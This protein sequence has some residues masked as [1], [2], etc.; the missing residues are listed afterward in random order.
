MQDMQKRFNKVAQNMQL[1]YTTTDETIVHPNISGYEKN[2]VTCN[3]YYNG[4]GRMIF[5]DE[6]TEIPIRF[7]TGCPNLKSIIIPPSCKLIENG[8]FNW[9]KNLEKVKLNEGLR[10]IGGGAFQGTG[11][12][13]ISIPSS[14]FLISDKALF[15]TPLKYLNLKE[16]STECR[17][18]ESYAVGRRVKVD[19]LSD[20]DYFH[21]DTFG[22]EEEEE[23][24]LPF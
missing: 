5:Q 14:C 18:F 22:R 10:I 4:I 1:L 16:P 6:I 9:C 7:L 2:K 17:Y 19:G 13:C 23:D 3:V 24:K 20:Y 11:I 21:P 12:K 15:K 8:A